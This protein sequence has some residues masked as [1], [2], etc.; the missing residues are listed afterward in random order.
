MRDLQ[1]RQQGAGNKTLPEATALT[2]NLRTPQANLAKIKLLVCLIA[3]LLI[4]LNI[5]GS[6]RCRHNNWKLRIP[7]WAAYTLSSYL[8]AYTLGLITEA[9]FRNEMLPVWA[10]FLMIFFGSSDSY[11]VHSLEDCERWKNYG[12]QYVIKFTGVIILLFM[13]GI[14]SWMISVLFILGL[15]VPL[16]FSNR[17]ASLLSASGYGRQMTTKLIADYMSSE[18]QSSKGDL[19]PCQMRGYNYVVK[20]GKTSSTPLK[21]LKEREAAAQW[22]AP[23]YRESLK[24]TDRVVTIEKVWKCDGWLLRSDGGDKDSK[25]KDIC[26]SFSLYKLLCLRF[27]GHSLPKQAHEKLW[28]LIQHLYAGGK[29]YERAF[30]VVE[31]ELSFLFDSFYTKYPIIFMPTG[32]TIKV[33]ELLLMVTGS[34]LTIGLCFQYNSNRHK[35][36]L[37][38]AT[39]GGWSI[40][41]L[42]TALILIVFTCGE[43][44]QFFFMAISEWAKVSLLCNYVQNPSWHKNKR[45]EK[46]IGLIC[47]T[48]LLKPWERKLRQYSLLESYD[49]NPPRWLYNSF[50]V[51]FIDLIRDG[52]KHSAPANLSS[53][54]KKAVVRSLMS[55]PETLKNGE[56]SLR[57]NNVADKFAWACR[58]EM[59]TQVIIVWHIATSIFEHSVPISYLISDPDYL[60]ATSLSKYLAYLVTFYSNLLPDH[61]HNSEYA[62]N[63]IIIETRCL[64]KA[65][66]TREE[67]IRTLNRISN[68]MDNNG[69]VIMQGA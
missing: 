64:L 20:V 59:Q 35:D 11:S 63:E 58:L 32:W 53:E 68:T 4:L 3:I 25:L 52:Q 48:Q 40:D 54:V 27:G 56:A 23:N 49:Y 21:K 17:A 19:D 55:N 16:K 62:F 1:R 69:R 5:F 24:I 34:L 37:Q 26:L 15:T 33:I 44:V 45:I 51:M 43:L 65:C 60:T 50:T 41:V 46:V 39:R 18:H 28:K 57:R 30:R 9:S 66:K 6:S 42:V 2:K 47:R 22:D 12:W 67:R 8:I 31:L 10:I 7:L 38:L 29:G 14:T 61:P 36:E 13:Y